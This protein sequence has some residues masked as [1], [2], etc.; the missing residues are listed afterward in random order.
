MFS[1]LIREWAMGT[2]TTERQLDRNA[3][4]AGVARFG[5]KSDAAGHARRGPRA[6]GP[7]R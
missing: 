5:I 6:A 1:I 4:Q 3:G 7:G 2:A